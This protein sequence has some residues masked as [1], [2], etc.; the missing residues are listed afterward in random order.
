MGC[1]RL[2]GVGGSGRSGGCCGGGGGFLL[3][4]LFSILGSFYFSQVQEDT[5][6][7]FFLAITSIIFFVI[8]WWHDRSSFKNT[9]CEMRRS[10]DIDCMYREVDKLR[11]ITDKLEKDC[12]KGTD[13]DQMLIGVHSRL[14]SVEDCCKKTCLKG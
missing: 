6:T 3:L 12:V 14:D 11:D 4:G 7:A 9:I 5:K 13:N 8:G 1:T 2:Y 10:E